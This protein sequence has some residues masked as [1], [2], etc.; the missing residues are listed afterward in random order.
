[1]VA[2]WPLPAFVKDGPTTKRRW[3]TKSL[4]RVSIGNSPGNNDGDSPELQAAI[5]DQCGQTLYS[6]LVKT[7]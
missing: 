7:V 3:N 1:M 6:F 2:V 5:R 4:A